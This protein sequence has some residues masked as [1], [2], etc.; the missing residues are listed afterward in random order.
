[1]YIL[2]K[3]IALGSIRGEEIVCGLM[4]FLGMYVNLALEEDLL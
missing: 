4:R 2:R 1:M 3:K